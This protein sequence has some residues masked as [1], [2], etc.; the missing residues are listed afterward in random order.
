ML[1]RPLLYL[2]ALLLS[3]HCVFVVGTG[4]TAKAADAL[5]PGQ[6]P[7]Q[8]QDTDDS[9]P[10]P[11]G[12]TGTTCN[13]ARVETQGSRNCENPSDEK[14]C[15]PKDPTTEKNCVEESGDSC[16]TNTQDQ[17]L[18]R[19]QPASPAAGSGSG[20]G[21]AGGGS[22]GNRGEA[23]AGGASLVSGSS[24]PDP[25]VAAPA[26]PAVDEIGRSPG[27]ESENENRE[28]TTPSGITATQPSTPNSS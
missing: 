5:P 24:E 1:M 11:Q 3:L 14:G 16:A 17:T 19:G 9:G 18:T 10:C 20:G 6:E 26:P 12:T 8:A 4:E 15:P 21:N 22:S 25:T 27:R 28:S 23:G 13:H 2:V 7:R